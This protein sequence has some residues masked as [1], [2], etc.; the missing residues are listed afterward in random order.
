MNLDDLEPPKEVQP[1]SLKLRNETGFIAST[2]TE[3]KDALNLHVSFSDARE[4]IL[5]TFKS[6]KRLKPDPKSCMKILLESGKKKEEKSL[7]NG[8]FEA[9]SH[10]TEESLN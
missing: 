3:E 9:F 6:N 7:P 8:V 1:M 4:A 10:A 2:G 5:E